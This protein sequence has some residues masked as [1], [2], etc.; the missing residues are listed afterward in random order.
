MLPQLLLRA[1]SP[2]QVETSPPCVRTPPVTISTR[3]LSG[4][5]C[6]Q[7]GGGKN[8]NKIIIIINTLKNKT[9]NKAKSHQTNPKKELTLQKCPQATAAPRGTLLLG[10]A[11]LIGIPPCF[12]TRSGQPRS[13]LVKA[14]EYL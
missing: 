2:K 4:V 10:E 3:G 6:C 1:T 14:L 11:V 7:V 5:L 12:A 13:M 8:N 9:Q